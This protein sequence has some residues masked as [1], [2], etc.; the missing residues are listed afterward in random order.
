MSDYQITKSLFFSFSSV[1]Q[2]KT[3]TDWLSQSAMPSSTHPQN[4]SLGK[5]NASI[6]VSKGSRK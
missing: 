3:A 6:I 5:K 1:K 2:T 4:S